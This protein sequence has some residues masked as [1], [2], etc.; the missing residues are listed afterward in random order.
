MTAGQSHESKEGLGLEALLALP[1]QTA[2]EFACWDMTNR[3]PQAPPEGQ[4]DGPFACER[5]YRFYKA[6]IDHPFQPSSAYPKLAGMS[7]KTAQAV[8]SSLIDKGY[9]R[10][11]TL[12]TK[13]RGRSA[14][15]LEALPAG[16]AAVARQEEGER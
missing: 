4:P 3:E 12:D 10:Q 15:V 14:L 7:S 9:V 13:G 8:R 2:Q 6:V 5:E 16:K 1:T 11:H